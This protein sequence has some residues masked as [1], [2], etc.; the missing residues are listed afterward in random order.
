MN[1][2]QILAEIREANI[3]YLLLAQSLLRTDRAGAL[4]Q[5]GIADEAA[6]VIERMT[7]AQLMKIASINTLLCRFQLG[8]D[9]VWDLIT[10]HGA[11]SAAPAADAQPGKPR[12]SA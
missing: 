11:A 6:Q 3:S 7:P 9:L 4:A 2:S 5:L 12:R 1:S 8:D 10:H